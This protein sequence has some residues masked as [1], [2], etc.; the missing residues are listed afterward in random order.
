[1]RC[2]KIVFSDLDGT[3]LDSKAKVSSENYMAIEALNK[4]GVLFVPSTG[5]SFSELPK[6]ISKNP[7]IRYFICSNGASIYDRKT[8]RSYLT[9]ISNKVVSDVLKIL[10]KYQVHLT[11][12]FDGGCHVDATYANSETFDYYNVCEAHRVVVND[13]S[14]SHQDFAEFCKNVD[15]VEVISVFFRSYRDL[16]A[17]RKSI[18]SLGGL[19]VAS[20]SEYNLEIM[21]EAA[22][23]GNALCWLTAELGISCED[24]ISVGDSDNDSTIIEAAGL[25]LAVSNACPTLKDIADGIICSNDEHV[26]QEIERRYFSQYGI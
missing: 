24:A 22:G 10:Y 20:V 5:R 16:Q 25:G 26:I 12:R 4:K 15:Q 1:M 23:K 19:R 17:S 11:I 13:Y 21:N 2:Y 9:A 18:E 7:F 6:E 3:L 8:G 14:I